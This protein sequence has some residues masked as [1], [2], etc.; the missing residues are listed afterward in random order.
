MRSKK[1]GRPLGS[2]NKSKTEDRSTS[3]TIAGPSHQQSSPLLIES[4]ATDTPAYEVEASNAQSVSPLPAAN[5]LIATE[6]PSPINEDIEIGYEI[7]TDEVVGDYEVSEGVLQMVKNDE[8]DVSD[9]KKMKTTSEI[10]DVGQVN[11]SIGYCVVKYED[12]LFAGRIIKEVEEK[13]KVSVMQKTFD[14]WKWP[15]KVEIITCHVK[16]IISRLEDHK[17]TKKGD[18]YA[19]DDQ[20]LYMEW[21]E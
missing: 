15:S 6:I 1:G 5:F 7:L 17:V 12:C 16:N 13:V 21:G 14:G 9:S 10:G 18:C 2:K 4:F 20:L 3:S 8:K 11:K 19:F